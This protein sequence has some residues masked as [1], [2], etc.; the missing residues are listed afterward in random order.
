MP[1]IKIGRRALAA[2]GPVAKPTT[3]FDADVKGFGL[4]VRATGAGFLE[5]GLYEGDLVTDRS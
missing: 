1:T 5:L 3:F 4:L 2:I